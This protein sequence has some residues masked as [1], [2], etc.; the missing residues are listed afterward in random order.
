MNTDNPFKEYIAIVQEL[1]SLEGKS[2]LASYIVESNIKTIFVMH[3]NWNAGIDYYDM[4]ISIPIQIFVRIRSKLT[5][6]EQIILDAFR[7]AIHGVDDSLR[8]NE[9]KLVP[10]KSVSILDI[11]EA[12]DDSMWKYNYYRLFIS[13]L[14][15][16]KLRATYIKK[17]LLRYGIDCFVAHE[18]IS[19]SKEWQIVIENALSSTDALC[20]ILS[21]DF[22]K[23]QWCDQEVGVALGRRKLVIPINSGVDPYGFIGK[24]QAIKTEGKSRIQVANAIFNVIC[25]NDITRGGYLEKLINLIIGAKSPEEALQFMDVLE[26]ISSVEKKY[27]DTLY[28][29]YRDNPIL[30]EKEYLEIANSIFKKNGLDA[31][32]KE[33]TVELSVDQDT[34][35]PF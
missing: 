34:D 33:K 31:I 1:V 26:R 18:D 14:S 29:H 10:S 27:I 20:A 35:L 12:D 28:S 25:T 11:P 30:M 16:D 23:S 7:D 19:P 6:E 9:V 17:L 13:H 22:S 32:K 5:E 3:D 2:E 8:I 24:W 15:K 4:A 21:P